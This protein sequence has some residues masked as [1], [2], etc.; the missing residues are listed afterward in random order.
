MANAIYDPK[1][2]KAEDF[3]NDGDNAVI[4]LDKTSFY[5]E[6]GGQVGDSGVIRI[7]ESV[8]EVAKTTKDP[9]GVYLHQGTLVGDGVKVGDKAVTVYNEEQRKATMRNHTAAHLLQAA[10]RETLG[11]HVEQ[12]GQ[13]VNDT[14][15]RFDFTHF[16]ALTSEELAAVENKVNE[17]ILSALDVTSTEMPIE[18]A[19]KMGA[20]ALFGEKYGDVVRVVKAGEFSTE[21]CGGTHVDNTGKLGL[22]KIVS[23]SSVAS[24]VRRIEAVTGTG[25]VEYIASL[26]SLIVNT[27]KAMKLGNVNELERKATAMAAELKEK[28]R[29]IAALSAQLTDLKSADI[30]S[31]AE[32]IGAV[33]LIIARAEDMSADDIRGLGDKAKEQGDDVVAVIACVN[34]EKGSANI[35]VACG[36][37]AVAAGAHAGAISIPTRYIHSNVEM[38]DSGDVSACVDLA[39]AFVKAV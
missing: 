4:V 22:F 28:E 11:S 14:A 1:S 20:M 2:L 21:L 30:F 31:A 6:S 7:G 33:K 15:M 32:Q 3:I 37:A 27:A 18:E 36:K 29:E 34:N 25:V 38:I 39:V 10:L 13:L 12:A 35:A 16:S 5:A 9:D 26:N 19:K 8:F 24:G 23:E 17:I